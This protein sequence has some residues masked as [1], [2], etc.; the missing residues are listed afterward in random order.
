MFK[1]EGKENTLS[2]HCVII[3]HVFKQLIL[4]LWDSAT[5]YGSGK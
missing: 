1:K 2:T 4:S 5:N 3:Q